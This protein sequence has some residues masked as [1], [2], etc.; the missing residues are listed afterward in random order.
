MR[1]GSDE[2]LHKFQSEIETTRSHDYHE[3]LFVSSLFAPFCSISSLFDRMNPQKADSSA[4]E[5]K[6]RNSLHSIQ[7]FKRLMRKSL[8][9]ALDEYCKSEL[10]HD[11][12]LIRI[13]I[14][15]TSP[16]RR[17]HDRTKPGSSSNRVSF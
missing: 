4:A 1:P 13:S 9:E 14:Y 17:C 3:L 11:N 15:H 8:S 2:S 7:N 6:L 12:V 10:P 16:F 5:T